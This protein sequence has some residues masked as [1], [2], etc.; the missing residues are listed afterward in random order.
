MV[1]GAES[2]TGVPRRQ[3]P[4]FAAIVACSQEEG[5]PRAWPSGRALRGFLTTTGL[6]LA[7]LAGSR[8][9][10]AQATARFADVPA[11]TPT[12]PAPAM[13]APPMPPPTTTP[14]PATP[15]PAPAIAA[16]A[17]PPA[18]AE[19]PAPSAADSQSGSAPQA[20]FTRR[21]ALSHLERAEAFEA[22]GDIAPA[23]REYTESVGIDP[24]LGDAYLRLGVLREKMGDPREA[25]LVFSEALMLP[26]TRAKALLERSHLRRKAGMSALALSDLESA[27]ELDDHRALLEE[28]AQDYVELHAWSAALAVF[29]RVAASAAESGDAPGLE[30][31]RLEVRALRV[32]AAETDPSQERPPR[33]DWVARALRSIARR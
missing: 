12:A 5:R 31:A 27:V 4:N 6:L 15:A 29:R 1:F 11:S 10:H 25:E 20:G 22:R 23:L 9:A 2:A 33:H 30:T 28:L 18:V 24:T 8:V 21:L 32:L 16:P 3:R 19:P 14:A 13:S 7:T 26:D 17:T